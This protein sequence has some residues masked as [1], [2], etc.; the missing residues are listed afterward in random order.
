ML[1]KGG[2][3]AIYIHPWDITEEGIDNCFDYLGDVC[4]LNEVYVAAVYHASTFVL[5][6][7]PKRMVRW[8]DGSVFFTPQHP[9]WHESRIQPIL[10]DCVDTSGYM[11]NIVHNARK[12]DWGVLFFTVFHFSHSMARAYP[13]ACCID[14][15]GER[16]HSCLCPANPDVRTY[17][18]AIV[19]DLMGTYGGDG[20]I[21]ESLGFGGWNYMFVV[22]K[23]ETMPSPRDQFLLSL[24]FCGSCLQRARDEGFD[25]IDLRRS[26]RDHLYENLPKNPKEWDMAPGDE[27]WARNAF[28]GQLWKYLEVRCNTVTSLYME[29]QE[30]VNR[31]DGAFMPFGARY[32]REVMGLDYSQFYPHLKRVSLSYKRIAP[33]EAERHLVEEVKKVPAWAEPEVNHNQRAFQSMEELRDTVF[34]ARKAGVRHHSFHYYGMSRHHELEWIGHAREAWK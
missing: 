2:S 22:N 15:M 9:R 6:H 31:F 33:D 28:N 7:N 10:G 24:C 26:I 21:Q 3:G 27:E 25:P 16:H 13:D 23:V 8:D 18:L 29:V 32:E 20:I 1:K 14:A 30:I 4:G 19:E 34:L 5:P 11:E 17:D 12:R